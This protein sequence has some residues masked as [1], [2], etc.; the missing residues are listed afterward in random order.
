MTGGGSSDATSGSDSGSTT[1]AA[2]SLSE[3]IG[4]G[5]TAD[6]SGWPQATKTTAKSITNNP[7]VICFI[8]LQSLLQTLKRRIEKLLP[9]SVLSP[10]SKR[11]ILA[12]F[13]QNAPFFIFS[14]QF[15]MGW[16][17]TI[18]RLPVTEHWLLVTNYG[19]GYRPIT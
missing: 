16:Q 19:S 17:F 11:R 1:G 15:S 14:F 4:V 18:H 8:I 6:P 2:G 13:Y 9:S 3:I 10:S 5:G 12:L 7:C